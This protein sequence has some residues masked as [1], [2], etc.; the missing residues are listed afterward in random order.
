MV[1]VVFNN[2]I[3]NYVTYIFARTT[4]KANWWCRITFCYI[5]WYFSFDDFFFL[6]NMPDVNSNLSQVLYHKNT[7]SC[8]SISCSIECL[9]SWKLKLWSSNSQFFWTTV[10]FPV[11]FH[12]KF[13]INLSIVGWCK[14]PVCSYW[15]KLGI[16]TNIICKNSWTKTYTNITVHFHCIIY[17]K[18]YFYF[19]LSILTP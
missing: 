12:I 13:C 8:Y 11:I 19:F 5:S 16:H 17:Y 15:T 7:Y 4:T 6:S 3:T 18:F 1:N 9:Q 14:R 2:L 10:T